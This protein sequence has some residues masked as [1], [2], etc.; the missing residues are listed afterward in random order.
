MTKPG[1]PLTSGGWAVT[2]RVSCRGVLGPG[3]GS[4]SLD[5]EGVPIPG[6]RGGPFPWIQRGSPD[7]EG[8]P[9]TRKGVSG[10]KEGSQDLEG[11]SPDQGVLDHGVCKFLIQLRQGLRQLG[12]MDT[13]TS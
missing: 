6:P 1:H 13:K 8:G 2:Q 4:L 10:S 9:Q 5:P 7:P 11:G 12:T 3:R